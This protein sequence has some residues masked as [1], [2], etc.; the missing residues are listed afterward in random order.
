M[1]G[2]VSS[3]SPVVNYQEDSYKGPK[4]V[5]V[6]DDDVVVRTALNALLKRRGY[7]PTLAENGQVA[8]DLLGS[9]SFDVVL[10]DSDMP[11]PDGFETI[12]AIRRLKNGSS[13]VPVIALTGYEISGF[14]EACLQ[15]GMQ[16]FLNKPI[17]P[18]AIF[19]AI[20][21]CTEPI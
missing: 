17:N 14:R 21:R 8:I 3:A 16:E 15:V 7:A 13:E 12:K 1:I 6:V 19:A 10:L 2:E 20:E 11:P 4:R 18:E 9:Q 5:L